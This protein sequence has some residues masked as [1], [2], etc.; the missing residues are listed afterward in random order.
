MRLWTLAFLLC[1]LAA[2]TIAPGQSQPTF[3]NT[4]YVDDSAINGA[5]DGSGWDDA[6]LNIQLA[7]AEAAANPSQTHLIKVAQG[8]YNADVTSPIS[9]ETASFGLINGC[10]LRGGYIGLNNQSIDEDT[11]N[12]QLYETILSGD[13]AGNDGANFTNRDDNSDHVVKAVNVGDT[14]LLDGF[15]VSSGDNTDDTLSDVTCGNKT[16]TGRGGAGLECVNSSPII[17]NCTFKLNRAV[18][19]GGIRLMCGSAKIVNC[20]FVDNYYPGHGCFDV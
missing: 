13:L 20:T 12:V 10:T 9:D 7:L 2:I 14:A 16:L 1:L 17:R 4:W 5:N 15:T 3:D 19:G 6:F 11:R 8:T 18:F